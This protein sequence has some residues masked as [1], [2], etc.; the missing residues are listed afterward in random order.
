MSKN[1]PMFACMHIH[2]FLEKEPIV[3][4]EWRKGKFLYTYTLYSSGCHCCRIGKKTKCLAAT[5]GES[6]RR[7]VY[8][9]GWLAVICTG[10]IDRVQRTKRWKKILERKKA[11]GK[12]EGELQWM[13]CIAA[14]LLKFMFLLY[15]HQSRLCLLGHD[16]IRYNRIMLFLAKR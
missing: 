10:L 1:L 12:K 2:P 3:T 15:Y 4:C 5:E 13:I 16:I 6:E 11:R 14:S 8:L 7:S 9:A